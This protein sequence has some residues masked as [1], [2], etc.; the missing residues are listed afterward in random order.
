MGIHSGIIF[1]ADYLFQRLFAGVG[2]SIASDVRVEED[3]DTRVRGNTFNEV[4]VCLVMGRDRLEVVTVT[5]MLKQ[6][7]TLILVGSGNNGCIC[8]TTDVNHTV[9]ILLLNLVNGV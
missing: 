4:V 2:E 7:V 9:T 5:Y 8:I 6:R 3:I 1:A